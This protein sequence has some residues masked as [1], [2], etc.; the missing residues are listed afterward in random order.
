M[1]YPSDGAGDDD[2]PPIELP[3]GPR[4]PSIYLVTSL[5]VSGIVLLLAPFAFAAVTARHPPRHDSPGA[6]ANV[7]EPPA[8]T[9]PGALRAT[10]GP[11]C[12]TG[13]AA[14]YHRV[15]TFFNE[16][17]GW[18]HYGS[19]CVGQTDS[20][21]ISGDAG[22]PNPALYAEWDF[23]T[24]PVSRGSCLIEVYVSDVDDIVYNGGNPAHYVVYG[25]I[26]G[27][28]PVQTFTVVQPEHL[29]SWVTVGSVPVTQGELRIVAT[30]EG[31]D[32]V[33]K[34]PTYRHISAGAVRVTCSLVASSYRRVALLHNS[35]G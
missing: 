13:R 29:A 11:G 22:I 32:A 20:I 4:P 31:K 6:T 17:V 8:A 27:G 21:P 23:H 1:V 10:A 33:N 25:S 15:G 24:E 9:S 16:H 30:N 3:A 5:A 28:D 7:G 14:S 12:P 2:L 19:G 18:L 34:V 35:Y 26:E